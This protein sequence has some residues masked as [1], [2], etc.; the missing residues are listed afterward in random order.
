M[1]FSLLYKFSF[2]SYFSLKIVILSWV[3]EFLENI[4]AFSLEQDLVYSQQ[5]LAEE[6]LL[7]PWSRQGLSYK[8]WFVCPSFY[9]P[10]SFLGIGSLVSSETQ[11]NVRG[12]YIVLC[13]RA[14][15]LGKIPHQV[16]MVKNGLK[17]WFLDF[18]RK[19][20]H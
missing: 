14:G 17:T 1:K 7:Y 13:E 5:S 10:I 12:P 3:V 18:L 16:K 11:H 2:L 15:F 9:L 6:R 20:H 4:L 8:I 19:S